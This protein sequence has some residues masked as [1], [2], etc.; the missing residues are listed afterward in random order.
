MYDVH[1]SAALVSISTSAPAGAHSEATRV[2]LDTYVR[3]SATAVVRRSV[4]FYP[5]PVH[6]PRWHDRYLIRPPA[7]VVPSAIRG[8]GALR[9]PLVFQWNKTDSSIDDVQ[10]EAG[11]VW[12]RTREAGWSARRTNV[13]VHRTPKSDDV[14]DA[15][16]ARS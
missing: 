11:D 2:G 16:A 15:P 7:V 5:A 12:W 14:D 4:P 9:A 3:R 6:G 8:L 10:A 1:A 13:D